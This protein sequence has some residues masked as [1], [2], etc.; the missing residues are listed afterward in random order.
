MKIQS[1]NILNSLE[2]SG[3]FFNF[4]NKFLIFSRNIQLDEKPITSPNAEDHSVSRRCIGSEFRNNSQEQS[5]FSWFGRVK[6][7]CLGIFISKFI[8][9]YF[10]NSKFL[11]LQIR[12]PAIQV[13]DI[14]VKN[15]LS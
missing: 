8:S 1:K 6:S 11:F 3:L 12:R 14:D 7:G 10:Q 9:N 4:E 13:G 2:I 5:F 15:I